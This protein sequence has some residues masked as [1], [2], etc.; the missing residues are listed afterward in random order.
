MRLAI[1]AALAAAAASAVG[2]DAAPLESR[3]VFQRMVG[4]QSELFSVRPDGRGL[5]RLTR[6]SDNDVQPVWA[7]DRRRLVALRGS[8]LVVRRRNGAVIR[9]IP[10]R[11]GTSTSEP[12]WSP[13]GR[14]ISY[15]VERC[16][17][18]NDPRGWWS[19]P[20]CADLW[21]VGADGSRRRRLVE[22]RVDTVSGSPSYA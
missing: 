3:I 16:E 5:K 6:A 9:S 15:L 8:G 21:I 1:A 14:W 10:V 22:A 17:D 4:K 19:Q 7:P 12:R 11:V 2:V 18:P 13:N 20:G